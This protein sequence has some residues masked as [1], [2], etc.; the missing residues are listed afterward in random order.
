M[1][2]KVITETVAKKL[3]LTN[4][5]FY[6]ILQ[7]YLRSS[8][9]LNKNKIETEILKIAGKKKLRTDKLAKSIKRKVIWIA[10]RQQRDF[11]K[12]TKSSRVQ[13]QSLKTKLLKAQEITR[14]STKDLKELL[15]ISV[16]KLKDLF[17]STCYFIGDLA[18]TSRRDMTS[19]GKE[20]KSKTMDS[21]PDKIKAY[22]KASAENI[23]NMTNSITHVIIEAFK[24]I[25]NEI[26][27]VE[28][29][30]S[31][32]VLELPITT[33][34]SY[35]FILSS[36]TKLQLYINT[37]NIKIGKIA[38]N[39]NDIFKEFVKKCVTKLSMLTY[40]SEESLKKIAKFYGDIAIA[41][42]NKD[43]IEIQQLGNEEYN[44]IVEVDHLVKNLCSAL[45]KE[46]IEQG[47]TICNGIQKDITA[48]LDCSTTQ[49]CNFPK[50]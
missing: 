33:N 48:L 15:E 39:T 28:Y 6:F 50:R 42:A 49:L 11:L 20:I 30:I 21:L 8:L 5:S 9:S 17:I 43:S 27:N 34:K 23:S 16:D 18:K 44:I 46:A 7:I 47:N 14:E 3:I 31:Q 45:N 1:S 26:K 40:K 4:N 32:C 13:L 35:Q 24:D 41:T 2:P 19:Y 38:Q 22:A 12:L 10:R 37:M 36:N 29:S 25:E